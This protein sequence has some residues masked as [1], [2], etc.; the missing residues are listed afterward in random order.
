M[1]L[2]F[3]SHRGGR[4]RGGLAVCRGAVQCLF[5]CGGSLAQV[6]Y[7]IF[8]SCPFEGGGRGEVWGSLGYCRKS[9]SC[10]RIRKTVDFHGGWCWC[11]VVVVKRA[12]ERFLLSVKSLVVYS[13][14]SFFVCVCF[15][16][17]LFFVRG[18][19]FKRYTL[20]YTV[21]DRSADI[22]IVVLGRMRAVTG[23]DGSYRTGDGRRA[24]VVVVVVLLVV[25][26]YWRASFCGPRVLFAAVAIASCLRWMYHTIR[27]DSVRA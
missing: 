25:L 20:G 6:L 17:M 24:N 16:S 21:V 18:H 10:R 5:C 14:S 9:E 27:I 8:V 3:D 1:F 22:L 2:Y 23:V 11:F 13:F 19:L 15:Q 26:A 12:H 7:A 4:G